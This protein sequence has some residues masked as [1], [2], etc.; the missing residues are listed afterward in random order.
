MRNQTNGCEHLL[1]AARR[2]AGAKER[3]QEQMQERAE[4]FASAFS[5]VAVEDT[6]NL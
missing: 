3:T 1:L 2:R 5:T 4:Q 6:K